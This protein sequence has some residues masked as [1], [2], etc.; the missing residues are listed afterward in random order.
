M[1]N[2]AFGS[3]FSGFC[4]LNMAAYYMDVFLA[5]TFVR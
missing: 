1:A 5:E 2:Y 3:H 4:H